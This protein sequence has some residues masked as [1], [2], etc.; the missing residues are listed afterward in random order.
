[1]YFFFQAED[2]IRDY[3]VTG[4]QTCALPIWNASD[5]PIENEKCKLSGFLVDHCGCEILLAIVIEIARRGIGMCAGIES[6]RLIAGA[7]RVH[8]GA[9]L[10]MLRQPGD[11]HFLLRRTEGVSAI[12]SGGSL[13][14]LPAGDGNDTDG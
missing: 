2:G 10:R 14:L 6:K 8:C 9:I 12:A 7:V 13:V 1:M 11:E 3:K 4:V 5:R